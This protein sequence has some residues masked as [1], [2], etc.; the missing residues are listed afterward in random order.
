MNWDFQTKSKTQTVEI[1]SQQDGACKN[2]TDEA[3][4]PR[5]MISNGT[6]CSD[7]ERD[8]MIIPQTE[9]TKRQKTKRSD[10]IT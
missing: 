8:E 5:S 9:G 3:V 7:S 10:S 1:K 4:K 6:D 2:I